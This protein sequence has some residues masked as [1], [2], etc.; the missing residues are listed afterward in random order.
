MP[1]L[2]AVRTVLAEG[3]YLHIQRAQR[4]HPLSVGTGQSQGQG[5]SPAFCRSVHPPDGAA[6]G[7]QRGVVRLPAAQAVP[8]P[9]GGDPPQ[10]QGAV[11]PDVRSAER[12]GCG[13]GRDP[14]GLRRKAELRHRRGP[15]AQGG[16]TGLRGHHGSLSDGERRLVPAAGGRHGQRGGSTAGVCLDLPSAAPVS[17]GGYR[18]GGC[19]D[20]PEFR[21]GSP[22]GGD[23]QL[24]HGGSLHPAGR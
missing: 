12:S 23:R 7:R 2:R 18:A 17:G 16:G 19:A 14:D 22:G 9:A 5:F 8:P 10:C 13:T 15:A 6:S 20:H 24:H 1:G 4:R 21:N 3:V 11:C